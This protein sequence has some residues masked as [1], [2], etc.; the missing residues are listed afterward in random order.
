MAKITR[1]HI[2]REITH[3]QYE[4]SQHLLFRGY[5]YKLSFFFTKNMSNVKVNRIITTRK[6]ISQI[7]KTLALTVEKLLARLNFQRE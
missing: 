5:G 3:V 2:L 1:T 7:M 6:M 4:S